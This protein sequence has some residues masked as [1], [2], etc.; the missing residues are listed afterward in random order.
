MTRIDSSASELAL[1]AGRD[2]REG[3]EDAHQDR[4]G[5]PRNRKPSFPRFPAKYPH[6]SVTSPEPFTEAPLEQ[7]PEV[8]ILCYTKFLSA[9]LKEVVA[10][11]PESRESATF[12][13]LHFLGSGLA[14]VENTGLLGASMAAV[15]LE[16]L[17]QLGVRSFIVLG[18]AGSLREGVEIGDVVVGDRAVRDEGTSY[19]YLP[20]SD[21]AWPSPGL[22][23]RVLAHLHGGKEKLHLGGTWTT[24]A[25]FRETLLEVQALAQEGILTVE[26]EAAALFSVARF[27]GV[28]IAAVFVVSDLVHREHWERGQEGSLLDASLL[29]VL[30]QLASFVG[31]AS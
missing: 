30:K 20:P 28:E 1:L 11:H 9:A 10:A 27:R 26:M 23:E 2:P 25:I 16:R 31:E 29:A 5:F 8:A 12:Q 21:Y 13:G 19:H 17:I 22:T 24:D 3:W 18:I 14:L 6:R 7:V 4:F 15:Q